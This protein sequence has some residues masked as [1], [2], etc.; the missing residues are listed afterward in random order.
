MV[1]GMMLD[2]QIDPSNLYGTWDDSKCRMDNWCTHIYIEQTILARN[3]EEI[4]LF[5]QGNVCFPRRLGLAPGALKFITTIGW[6]YSV[7]NNYYYVW[8]FWTNIRTCD[9]KFYP[10]KAW[11]FDVFYIEQKPKA[12]KQNERINKSL[13]APYRDDQIMCGKCRSN[14]IRDQSWKHTSWLAGLFSDL[15]CINV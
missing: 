11:D 10:C 4:A 13:R 7:E 12:P 2:M 8:L 5:C 3:D 14:Q 15:V 9:S 1:A 6:K